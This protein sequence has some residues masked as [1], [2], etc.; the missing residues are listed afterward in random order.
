CLDDPGAESLEACDPRLGGV[1]R[2]RVAAV[3]EVGCPAQKT[4][5]APC[6]PRLGHGPAGEHRPERGD[7][8]DR[9]TERADGVEGGA[10]GE[11]AVD[12]DVPETRL[13]PDDVAGGGREADRAAGVGADPEIAEAARDR[14]SVA[15][16]GA[17]RGAARPG[18]V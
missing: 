13:E 3:C 4:D 18:R 15:A 10:E 9:P 14:R 12:G 6:E 5:R 7:V 17:A 8:G 16:R 2:L 1:A 11:N